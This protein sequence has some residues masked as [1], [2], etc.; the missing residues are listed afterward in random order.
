MPKWSRDIF[1]GIVAK[2]VFVETP[3]NKKDRKVHPDTPLNNEDQKVHPAATEN[4]NEIIQ[5]KEKVT[6]CVGRAIVNTRPT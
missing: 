1:L 3:L 5:V 4:V 2:F 6:L